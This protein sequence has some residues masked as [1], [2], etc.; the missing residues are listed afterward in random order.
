MLEK[1]RRQD[2]RVDDIVAMDDR[3]ISL[4]EY[5]Q[6][7]QHPGIRSRQNA[8]IQDMIG[9]DISA[10]NFS[11]VVNQDLA[12][13][14]E[15]IDTKLNYLI[16]VNMV[17]DANRSNLKERPINL[18]VTGAS[19]RTENQYKKGDYIS[20]SLMLPSFPPSIVELVAQVTWAKKETTAS[21]YIGVHFLY[22]C[23]DE[24]SSISSHVFKRHRE[25]IRLQSKADAIS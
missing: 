20:L 12:K 1:N 11:S 7:T 14:L 19:F 25:S 23:N 13:A 21:T 5:Q 10:S 22:R 16:G 4:A 15:T 2:F 3:N 18:S 24:E 8:M 9:K 17:N 6:Q